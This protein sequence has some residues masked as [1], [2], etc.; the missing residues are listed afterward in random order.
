M[1]D[2][3]PL[4]YLSKVQDLMDL[5]DFMD[6]EDFEAALEIALKCIANPNPLPVHARQALVQMQGYA[7]TF[8][9]KGQAYMTIKKGKAGTD[10]NHKKNVYFSVSEQCHELAQTLKYVAKEHL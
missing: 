3:H 2:E 10:E 9:M 8:R 5:N 7:F 1:S 4:V 6:D